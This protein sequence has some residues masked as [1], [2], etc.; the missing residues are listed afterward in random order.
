ME[1][2]GKGARNVTDQNARNVRSLDILKQQ[3]AN[4]QSLQLQR[5]T[6]V[7]NITQNCT[8]YQDLPGITA[9]G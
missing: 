5:S 1:P 3:I 2:K 4:Q 7:S 6:V 9:K 8:R